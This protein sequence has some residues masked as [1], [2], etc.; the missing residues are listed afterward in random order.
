M[1]LADPGSAQEF[2]EA[3]IASFSVLGGTMAYFSG[4]AAYGALARAEPSTAVAQGIN[5]GIAE[6]FGL[7]VPASIMALM[8]MGWGW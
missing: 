5:E 2:L 8:I 3:I 4:Y 6:G 1:V 7:G